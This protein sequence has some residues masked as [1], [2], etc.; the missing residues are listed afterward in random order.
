M[1]AKNK[2][3]AGDYK[4]A[5]VSSVLGTV[6]ILV[7]LK[8]TI[9]IKKSTVDAYE[10][11]TDEQR[12]SAASGIA[13]GAVGAA[14]LGPVGLLAGLSAKNKGT[15]TVAIKFKDGKNSLIEI[16]DKIYKTLLKIL[17]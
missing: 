4:G 1:G 14:L 10:V 5:N 17:F 3:I 11:I 7:S 8:E 15:Y 13:R 6:S 2:V 16:N 9:E 12:K